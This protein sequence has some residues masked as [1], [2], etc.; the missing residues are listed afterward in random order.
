MPQTWRLSISCRHKIVKLFARRSRASDEPPSPRNV[1]E[2]WTGAPS[3]ISWRGTVHRA[4]PDAE[5]VPQSASSPCLCCLY[6][7]RSAVAC[8]SQHCDDA[9]RGKP[10]TAACAIRT[11]DQCYLMPPFPPRSPRHLAPWI[12]ENAQLVLDGASVRRTSGLTRRLELSGALSSMMTSAG[13]VPRVDGPLP[14]NLQSCVY[15]RWRLRL[16]FWAHRSV[17]NS[18]DHRP[19]AHAWVIQFKSLA[20]AQVGIGQSQPKR[21]ARRR[22]ATWRCG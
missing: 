5:I 16:T 4:L 17:G 13:T 1:P 20:T 18:P 6:C 22:L 9:S 19:N 12:R 14:P 8:L 2:Q 15:I 10:A 11:E 21:S 3:I 7:P